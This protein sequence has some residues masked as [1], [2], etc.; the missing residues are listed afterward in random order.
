VPWRAAGAELR[1]R[2]CG[3]STSPQLAVPPR[4]HFSSAVWPGFWC[5]GS[6][7]CPG[8]WRG[9]AS[10]IAAPAVGAPRVVDALGLGAGSP[11]CRRHATQ[12]RA[13]RG[14]SIQLELRRRATAVDEVV[15]A[16][17]RKPPGCEVGGVQPRPVSV[18]GAP[19]SVSSTSY[20]DSTPRTLCCATGRCPGRVPPSRIGGCP[21]SR[22]CTSSQSPYADRCAAS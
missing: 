19:S 9:I 22:S 3:S 7:P 12:M 18:T 6:P 11:R 10:R 8:A 21:S 20:H 17:F 2:G 1:R 16:S 13:C 14:R 15:P 5:C 4:G